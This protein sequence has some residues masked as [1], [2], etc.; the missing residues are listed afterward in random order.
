M[1]WTKASIFSG[2]TYPMTC[3][4]LIGTTFAKNGM[5]AIF[6]FK[7]TQKR[8]PIIKNILAFGSRRI[9]IFISEFTFSGSVTANMPLKMTPDGFNHTK[10]ESPAVAREDALQPIQLLLQY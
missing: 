6:N 8:R 10:Q 4:F 1:F 5:A 7:F 2:V 3:S 9:T